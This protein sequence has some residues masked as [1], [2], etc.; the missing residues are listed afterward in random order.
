LYSLGATPLAWAQGSRKDDIV[1]NAQGRPMAGANVRVCGSGAAGQPCTPLAQVYSDSALTQALANPLSSDGLGNYNFYAAPGRYM[2]ELSGPG[3]T[4]KQIPNVILP[5]DPSSPTFTSVTTTSG[6]S[7]FSLSLT[8]NLTVN[9][10]TAVAGSVTVGGQTIP[11]A[12]QDN[13]WM[14]GQ[15]FKGPIPWRDISA[16]MPAGGCSTT[17]TGT[18]TTTGSITSGTSTLTLTS[19]QGFK[20]GCGIGVIGAGPTSTL[21]PPGNGCSISAISR[22]SN[23][24]TVTCS[25]PH[26]LFV[27]AN[28]ESY[29]V[30]IAGVTDTSFNRTFLVATVPDTTHITYAQTAA[31]ASSS[32]GTA[33]TLWGYAHG[34]TGSTTYNYKF[35]GIDANLGYSA[36]SGTTTITNGNATL[37]VFD[38]NWLNVPPVLNS[39]QVAIYSDRGLGGA[40]T[41]VGVTFT[42]A[43]S[44]YGLNLPCPVSLPTNPPVAAGPQMLN[45]T[46]SA[47]GGSTTLTLATTASNT[48]TTKGVYHDE[49]SFLSSCINDVNTDQA[50]IGGNRGSSYGCY[51]PAGFYGMNGDMVTDT[52]ITNTSS[53]KIAVAGTLNFQVM[54]W[55]VAHGLWDIEG[56]GGGGDTGSFS[57]E[58]TV[59]LV[60]GAQVPAGF[61]MRKSVTA[62]KI[63]G[64]SFGN[65]AGHGI[66]VGSG[67][68]S[69]GSQA[70]LHFENLNIGMAS[71]SGGAALWFDNNTIGVWAN[72][73]SLSGAQNGLATVMV[74][75][76]AYGGTDDCC[77]YFDNITSLYH[78]IRIDAPGGN[79]TGGQSGSISLRNWLSEDLNDPGFIINDAGPNAPGSASSGINGILLDNVDSS[80][81]F[82]GPAANSLIGQI[83]LS[84]AA[85]PPISISSMNI[86][87][88]G[89]FYKCRAA[90]TLCNDPIAVGALNI[91]GPRGGTW[92]N[93]FSIGGGYYGYSSPTPT[94][95]A[96]YPIQST[97]PYSSY[98]SALSVPA[99]EQ[100]LPPPNVFSVTGTGAGSLSAGTYCMK[101][102]GIDAKPGTYGEPVGETLP[103]NEIC[104]TVGASSSI[105][106]QF[107]QAQG[108]MYSG[109]R[110]YY[111]TGAPG[112]EA[113]YLPLASAA[114]PY[115]YT[116]TSTAGNVS[117]TPPHTPTA[118]LSWLYWDGG[119]HSCLYCV[120]TGA[121]TSSWS[122]GVGDP[123]PP[124]G[125]KLSVKGGSLNAPAY[126]TTPNCAN[127]SGTCTSAAAGSVTVAAGSTSVTVATTAVTANSE[128]F[129]QF[130]SSLGTRLGVTCN[131]TVA[132]PSVT[133]RTAATSFVL[134]IP[135]A[136]VTNP[137]CFSYHIVN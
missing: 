30:V 27:T 40:L 114:G 68:D 94:V 123:S 2:I 25:A 89:Y 132:L 111:T 22:T 24:V 126:T 127:T 59:K 70:G 6:I 92:G 67:W 10:S 76:S 50:A 86:G 43:Y 64:F 49:T 11:M 93:D 106:I 3:I 81:P 39:R 72:H 136:P 61:V 98:G 69:G 84:P 63:K 60:F 20:N 66:W 133:A 31:N 13:Q 137:A 8:G 99:W 23:V 34:V 47:G 56:V 33:N 46:I 109:F 77:M 5:S 97:L 113:N 35:V 102:T 125:S 103:T 4:T 91:N 1:F 42:F 37:G 53:L 108:W 65:L 48:A 17:D 55:Y 79:L 52:L 15:R 9:G 115:T 45:T 58:P 32:S 85:N 54:P 117:A 131:T 82:G 119:P 87:G 57:H 14:A 130:D 134:T 124:T 16:Y 41:C 128:I 118:D 38:Y 28:T 19:A 96:G 88:F 12:N 7:A 26:G 100:L 104:Q 110:L 83:G 129:V 120:A 36:A 18:P 78:G 105:T 135:A 74:T 29:G 73:L 71:N 80:D 90:S 95:I 122:L 51:I 112:S 75:M 44:D 107:S 101:V 116:F 121:G 62:T 21:V